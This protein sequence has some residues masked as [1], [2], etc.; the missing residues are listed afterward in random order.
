MKKFIVL[1]LL[2]LLILSGLY[3]YSYYKNKKNSKEDTVYFIP[4]FHK[5]LF[6]NDKKG[7][8][9]LANIIEK[10]GYKVIATTSYSDLKDAKYIVIFDI[11]PKKIRKIAKLPK[12]KL[13]LFIWEPPVVISQNYQKKYQKY[14]KKIFTFNDDLIDNKKF[15]KFYYPDL[16]PMIENQT[17]FEDKKLACLISAE[18]S[19]THEDELYSERRKA[20]KFFEEKA[21]NDFD[22]YGFSWKKQEF[23]SYKGTVQDKAIVMNKYKF[24]IC[25][26][27]AKNINGYITEKIFDSFKAGCVPVYLGAKN[28]T[29]YI[30]K[31]C[32]IDKREF[33]SYNELY[34]YLKSMT[35]EEYL[36]YIENIKLFLNSPKATLFSGNNIVET[37]LQAIDLKEPINE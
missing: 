28:I 17:A 7:F 25:Y 35:K 19:S 36:T 30:P 1:V 2:V 21:E 34:D 11:H 29:T 24:S 12:D 22:L 14:F 31:N 26:E 4:G 16:K 13:I 9:N 6:G 15:F 37:F 20:I 23:K 33:K 27:N 18:K 32:F 5:N 8:F 3:I 10:K